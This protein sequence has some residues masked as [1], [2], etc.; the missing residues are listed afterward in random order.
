LS[1]G[2]VGDVAEAMKL[3]GGLCISCNCNLHILTPVTFES[4]KVCVT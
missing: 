4:V 3:G 2:I 1:V